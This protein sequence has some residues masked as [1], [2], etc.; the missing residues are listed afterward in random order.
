MMLLC[1]DTSVGTS[2]AL[3]ERDEIF[4]E[5]YEPDR[6]LHAETIGLF[7]QR[8]TDCAGE[9]SIDAVVAGVGPGPFTGL[10][11]GIAAARMSAY[12]WG[13]PL[14]A[15][16]SHDAIARTHYET[17]KSGSVVVQTDAKRNQCYWSA[18]ERAEHSIP[19]R[20]AG[21]SLDQQIQSQYADWERVEGEVVSAANLGKIAWQ[22]HQQGIAQ[23][24]LEALYLR[25][26]DVTL[27]PHTKKV[28][29]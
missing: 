25:A 12:A 15:V 17:G 23:E 2:V 1:I 7:L 4:W 24:R 29:P 11:V 3:V 21:P 18:Y 13:V 9:R 5:A 19:V 16:V 26:P 22:K 28:S 20:R 10:R 8:A 27:S 6:F 14:W